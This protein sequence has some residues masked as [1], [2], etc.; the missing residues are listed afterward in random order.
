VLGTGLLDVLPGQLGPSPA[1]R[2]SDPASTVVL[3]TEHGSWN[4]GAD[5][6]GVGEVATID[7]TDAAVS[8]AD[9]DLGTV[10]L[11]HLD[12]DDVSRRGGRTAA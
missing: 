6:R 2:Q 3:T 8:E 7:Y 10:N 4:A 9:L 1:V 11:G 12:V 5:D